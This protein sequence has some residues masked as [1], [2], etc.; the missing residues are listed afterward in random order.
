MM[1]FSSIAMLIGGYPG[2]KPPPLLPRE[3]G[4]MKTRT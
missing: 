4:A 3:E 2:G 1:A